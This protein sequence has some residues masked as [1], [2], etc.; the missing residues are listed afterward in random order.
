MA[1]Y[2]DYA[3]V[4][5]YKD[6]VY[7]ADTDDDTEIGVALTVASRAIDQ[8]CDRQFGVLAEAAVRYQTADTTCYLKLSLDLQS[9][10][11]LAV[12][13]DS[14]RDGIY[15]TT[16]TLG[17]HVRL[18]PLNAPSDGRPWTAL[19]VINGSGH[20]FPCHDGAVEITAEWGWTAV[21]AAVKQACLLQADIYMKRRN[22]GLG[23]DYSSAS[24]F[25][26]RDVQGIL[27]N[28]RRWWGVAA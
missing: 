12:K 19:E 16:L 15:E 13:V 26:D 5:D 25:L 28:Y 18:L 23:Q 20:W 22:Q 14:D 1:L 11:D 10:N 17:T 7:V 24:K 9:T 27:R 6:W 3:T 4:Q 21:P 8:Y 2:P